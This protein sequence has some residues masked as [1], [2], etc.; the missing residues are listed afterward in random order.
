MKKKTNYNLS[1]IAPSFV[2]SNLTCY[3]QETIQ[4]KYKIKTLVDSRPEGMSK[5][6]MFVIVSED[7]NLTFDS[8]KK[9]YYTTKK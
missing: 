7:V 4:L 5:E 6:E 2:W 8:I 9:I 1:G 3:Q